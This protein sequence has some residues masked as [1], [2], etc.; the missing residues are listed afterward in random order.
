M[1]GERLCAQGMPQSVRMRNARG[2]EIECPLCGKWRSQ[3]AMR[4]HI[5][6]AHTQVG[7]EQQREAGR[8]GWRAG[9]KEAW[10]KQLIRRR[11]L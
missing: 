4:Q 2:D 9:G 8:R 5:E 11:G 1:G 6:Q 7:V 10:W 3:R